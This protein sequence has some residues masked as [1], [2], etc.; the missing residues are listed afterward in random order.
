MHRYVSLIACIS[1]VVA[2]GNGPA[3]AVV[4]ASVGD[5]PPAA[6][7]PDNAADAGAAPGVEP[8]SSVD[9]DGGPGPFAPADAGPAADA[10]SGT[11]DFHLLLGV[12][13]SDT[14]GDTLSL[15]G[16]NYTDLI[17]SNYV[18]GVMYGHLIEKSSPGMLFDKDYLY[19][20]I[21][22]QLLQEN[23]DTELYSQSSDLIDPSPLQQAVMGTGQ[24]GPYQINNYAADMVYGTYSPQG[25]S[26]INYVAVQKNIGFAFASA[27]TQYTQATP[28]S[29]NDKY[30]GPMLTA[31]FH[32]ND[33]VALQ[34]IGPVGGYTPQWEPS[35][36]NALTNFEKLPEN[37]LDVLLNVAYNQGYYGP[38][39]TSYSAEGATATAATVATVDSYAS[40]LG[41]NDTYQQYPYQVRY[42]LD[43]LYDN[44]APVTGAVPNNHVVFGV[45]WLGGIF[46]SC[47]ETLAYVDAS[48]AYAYIS[49]AQATQAFDAA[50]ATSGLSGS[51]TLDLSSAGQRAQLFALLEQAIDA[52]ESSLPTDFATT[53]LTGL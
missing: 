46:A 39:V 47:F 1:L 52:L 50:L 53:T 45:G 19:G 15:A 31:Y 27:A 26:L 8:G 30:Y 32:F 36:D 6:E 34:K 29:F 41:V 3:A 16:D 49:Q 20:S 35:Y 33:Y 28:P 12:S 21:F 5:D 48:S 9:S 24:G 4:G 17:A 23:L 22:G 44:P 37:F 42:Y 25:Y 38:L 13:G 51:A 43:Q 10:S 14:P 18:A 40:V 7:T 2:C 11:I